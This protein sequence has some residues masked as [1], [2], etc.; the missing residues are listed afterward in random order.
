[1]FELA[2]GL[3][4]VGTVESFEWE[5]EKGEELRRIALCRM[6]LWQEHEDF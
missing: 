5:E 6:K 2:I 3:I 1:M 4:F